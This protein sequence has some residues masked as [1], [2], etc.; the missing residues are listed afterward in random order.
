MKLSTILLVL[1][2][3]LILGAIT[4][5]FVL[6]KQKHHNPPPPTSK[7][8]V[9]FD[10]NVRINRINGDKTERYNPDLRDCVKRNTM[11]AMSVGGMK[12][13]AEKEL[14]SIAAG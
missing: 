3:V 9:R 8:K 14:S 13:L 11:Q 6:P 1:C 7:K 5:S 12:A 10:T 4:Y 2:I